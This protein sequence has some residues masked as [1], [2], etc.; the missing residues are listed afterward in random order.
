M[1]IIVYQ[2]PAR[3]NGLKLSENPLAGRGCIQADFG[4]IYAHCK[5]SFYFERF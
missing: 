4:V 2:N 3:T 5:K 1:E